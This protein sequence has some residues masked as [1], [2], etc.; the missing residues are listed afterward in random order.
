M[1]YILEARDRTR[2]ILIARELRKSWLLRAKR[3]L[4]LTLLVLLV[5]VSVYYDRLVLT[6]LMLLGGVS[7]VLLV[8]VSDLAEARNSS[9]G[10]LRFLY[11]T[12]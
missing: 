3:A 10:G 11:D 2:Q 4:V 9:L 5:V 12:S 1:R 8:V 6:L 7:L